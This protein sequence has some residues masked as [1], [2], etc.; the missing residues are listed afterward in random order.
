VLAARLTRRLAHPRRW[1]HLHRIRTLDPVAD[2]DEIVRLTMRQEFPWDYVQG[3]GIAFMR[4]YGVPSI[5]R[6][7]DR[8]GEFEHDGVKRYDDTLLIGEE[9]GADGLDSPRGRATVRRL[10]RIHGH[11]DIPNDEF[12]YVLATTLVGPVRWISR[13][14]W[15]ELDPVELVALTRFT[16]RFGELMGIKGLPETYDGYLELLTSYERERFEF[17]PANKRVTEATIRI[18]RATAP[19]YLKV[20]FRRVSIALMDE[21]LRIALGMEE[22]PRWLVRAVDLGLRLRAKALRFFPPRTA[23]Y[24]R[25]HPTYPNGYQL[26]RIGPVT[27]LDELNKDTNKDTNKNTNKE[28]HVA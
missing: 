27:M 26:S 4:D 3:A 18:G 14:G 9:A 19:W 22:Q 25:T 16:T 5:A 23:P 28:S 11:Y 12:Q 24:E 17:D 15:R 1:D 20:G 8:T 6:L 2:C 21:P 10:N 13:Y 7:L